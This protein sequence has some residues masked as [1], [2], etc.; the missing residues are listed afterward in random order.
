MIVRMEPTIVVF[1]NSFSKSCNCEKGA[2]W[3]MV[4]GRLSRLSRPVSNCRKP[5]KISIMHML[6]DSVI[7][8]GL[9]G[10]VGWVVS[11]G[12]PSLVGQRCPGPEQLWACWWAIWAAEVGGKIGRWGQLQCPSS[13][14]C[15]QTAKHLNFY[16]DH[17]GGGATI[18][19]VSEDSLYPL[20]RFHTVRYQTFRPDCKA[21]FRTFQKATK[22]RANLTCK[23]CSK[24][25]VP[26]KKKISS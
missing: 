25:Q 4:T 11:W 6:V 16:W 26:L 8:W 17:R 10:L 5:L 19:L 18:N 7:R 13:H 21:M 1:R 20:C 2:T 15:E 14:K 23:W 9:L 22:V 3:R 12:L 24:M